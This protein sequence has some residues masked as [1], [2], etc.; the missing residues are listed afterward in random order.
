MSKMVKKET[1]DA[2]IELLRSVLMVMIILFHLIVHGCK[3]KGLHL[4]L[5]QPTNHDFFYLF[6]LSFL[7]VAVNCFIFISGYYGINFKIK[8][9]ISFWAQGAFYALGIYLCSVFAF[10]STSFNIKV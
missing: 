8:T 5:Y 1:R 7:C 6:A 3:V 10:N 2:N 9:L 4:S